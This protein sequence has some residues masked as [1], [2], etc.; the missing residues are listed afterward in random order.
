[1]E[2]EIKITSDLNSPEYA[3]QMWNLRISVDGRL[4]AALVYALIQTGDTLVLQA[5]TK[6]G[7]KEVARWDKLTFAPFLVNVFLVNQGAFVLA[8][9][10]TAVGPRSAEGP[11]PSVEKALSDAGFGSAGPM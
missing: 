8:T 7:V 11:T 5:V 4:R 2:S 6:D 1:M 9:L 10:P 3:A